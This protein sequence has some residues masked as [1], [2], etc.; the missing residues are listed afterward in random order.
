LVAHDCLDL[1]VV[2]FVVVVFAVDWV[3]VVAALLFVV[4]GCAWTGAAIAG[5]V[6]ARASM[7]FVCAAVEDDS[8]SIVVEA[9]V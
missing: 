9:A 2:A 5:D 1:T 4:D 3:E 6:A 8:S 7:V